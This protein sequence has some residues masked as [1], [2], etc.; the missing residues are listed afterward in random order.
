MQASTCR[1]GPAAAAPSLTWCWTLGP[2][3]PGLGRASRPTPPLSSFSASCVRPPGT[4]S[5]WRPATVP[6]VATRAPSLPPLTMTAV[7]VSFPVCHLHLSRWTFCVKYFLL[8]SAGTIPP[9]KSARG[10]GDDV[11]KLFSIGSPVILVTLGVA[12]LFIVRKKRKEKRLKRLRGER[13][14]ERVQRERSVLLC[15]MD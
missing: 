10:E 6:G 13:K 11:K 3:A 2:K 1:D 9:I 15:V 4:S 12:L 7:S 14:K 8:L 5:K